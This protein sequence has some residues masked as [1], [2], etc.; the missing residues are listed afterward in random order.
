MARLRLT[1]LTNRVA[2][3]GKNPAIFDR[4]LHRCHRVQNGMT[5]QRALKSPSWPDSV[6]F[7]GFFPKS[8][9]CN[10]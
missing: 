4:R 3:L 5:P 2:R 9:L 1:P 6:F 10:L 7:H 8:N